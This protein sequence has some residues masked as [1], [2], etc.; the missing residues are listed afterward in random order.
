MT[1]IQTDIAQR[2]L[3]SG[4]AAPLSLDVAKVKGELMIVSPSVLPADDPLRAKAREQVVRLI[5]LPKDRYED[6]RSAIDSA[7]GRAMQ[8]ASHQSDM[9][10]RKLGPLMAK[11]EDGSPVALALIDLRDKVKELD[12]SDI[13]FTPGGIARAVGHIP[14]IGTPA[15]R[16]FNRFETGQD[17]IDSI[18]KS[19][20]T[21]Q[22]TLRNN[23][24]ILSTDQQTWR[25]TTLVLQQQ[26]DYQKMV[27][28]DLDASLPSIT[29]EEQHRF[30]EEEVLFPL[31]QRTEDILQRLAVNQQGVLVSEIVIRNNRELIRG[32][33]RAL[34][35]TIDALTIAIEAATALADQKIVLDSVDA[36]NTTTNTL[37][38]GTAKRLRT[39]GVEIHKRA[40]S[41]MLA[42]DVLK[43]A[44]VDIHAALDDIA[45]YR[46]DAL[47]KMAATIVE[48]DKEAAVAE[49]AI[50]RMERGNRVR[51]SNDLSFDLPATA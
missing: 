35:V 8:A 32:V 16:Y 4:L 44:F 22:A 14:F 19:L 2:P 23:N 37:I 30:L 24:T 7:G 36:L 17:A 50:Q 6:A 13:D 1:D 47:P 49:K 43:Q 18:I 26:I 38:A 10:K 46:R 42:E 29:D 45:T 39:Q 27:D 48:L 33:D 12:P 31:R 34:Y 11:T 28:E 5:A 20:Q 15:K 40:S 9:L 25:A 41:T 21:G 51:V 3:P